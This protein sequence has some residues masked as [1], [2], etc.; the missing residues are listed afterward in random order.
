MKTLWARCCTMPSTGG[1]RVTVATH[2]R[3]GFHMR[4]SV[5]R[6]RATTTLALARVH[7]LAGRGARLVQAVPRGPLWWRCWT[8][9]ISAR[10]SAPR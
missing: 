8:R 9:A 4:E 2:P 1:G 10:A 6:I 5:L 3:V 7:Q